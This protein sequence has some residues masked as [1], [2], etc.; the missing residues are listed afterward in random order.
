MSQG[1]YI[2]NTLGKTATVNFPDSI[3][4][5][6]SVD[7]DKIVVKDASGNVVL[8][9]NSK[10]QGDFSNSTI[11]NR[12]IIQSSTLNGLSGVPI[13]P[14]G[15]ATSSSIQCFNSSDISNGSQAYM[16]MS[17]DGMHLVS[18][19]VGTGTYLPMM[20]ITSGSERMRIAPNG[21][22]S[23]GDILGGSKLTLSN[24]TTNQYVGMSITNGYSSGG[25]SYVDAQGINNVTDSSI[26]FVHNTDYSSAIT[27]HTQAAGTNTDRRSH[28]LSIEGNGQVISS[29]AGFSTIGY[30]FGGQQ[31]KTGIGCPSDGILGLYGDGGIL[32]KNG[33][34]GYGTGA[35]GT[36]TQLTSKS[37]AVTLNK[38]S[39]A[40]IT[41]NSALSAGATTGFN[42][43]NSLITAN[44]T[45]IVIVGG[46]GGASAYDVWAHYC[47]AGVVNISIKNLDSVSRSDNIQISFTII[48]GAIA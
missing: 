22:I 44:D 37:T 32:A 26:F 19:K 20:F 40:I 38:P 23:I 17:F 25:T 7:I 39:G 2:K 10:I 1:L 48:K 18:N 36:V 27:F 3:N 16:G 6:I 8:P 46:N 29:L 33:P 24:G 41:S 5:D 21:N 45:V 14:N 31:A 28:K 47:I 11:A 4:S 9:S 13:L 15:T 42:L 12:T 34:L 30:T 35:G 43:N